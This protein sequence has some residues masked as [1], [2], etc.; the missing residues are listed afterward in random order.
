M[1]EIRDVVSKSLSPQLY[2][3]RYANVLKG[4]EKWQ[5]L[6]AP[7]GE[8]YVW[9]EKSTYIREPPWFTM[10]IGKPELSDVKDAR[11]LVMLGDKITT[12]HISPA[13]SIPANTPAANYLESHGV[14]K[15]KFSTYGS[16]RGNHE[17]MVRGAFGNIREGALTTHFPSSE[18]MTIYEAASRYEREHVP[19]I[20]LA[21]KRYGAGSSRDWA[22]KAVK[23]LGVRAVVAESYE[24][25][26]RSNLIAMGVLP[27]E[28]LPGESWKSLNLRGDE[29]F[30]IEGIASIDPKSRL[31]IK[32]ESRKN[33]TRTFETNAKLDNEVEV[34]YL[35]RGGV[36]PYVFAK[37]T[38]R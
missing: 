33:G 11:A 2:R 4:D 14:P 21:G 28:F 35:H 25:I 27:L 7:A 18:L 37:L 29:V 19:L 22:A 20:I 30:S 10:D 13:G 23:L 31:T 34:E 17:V 24:R 12:D 6:R 3:E 16:R 1:K 38:E 9:D 26:H 36:L 5:N 8:T 32:A 15:I